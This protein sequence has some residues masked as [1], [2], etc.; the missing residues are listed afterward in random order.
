MKNKVLAVLAII[1]IIGMIVIAAIGF[2]VDR[3][4]KR[5]SLVEISIGKEFNINDIKTITDEVFQNS[6]VEIQKAGDFKDIVI[7]KTNEINDE[8]KETL[9]TKINEKYG[10]ENTIENVKVNE[11]SNFKLRDLVKPYIIPV[12]ISTILIL[13]YM[14]IRFKKLGIGKVI[15][16]DVLMIII[17]ELLYFAIIAI[18]RYPVNSLVMPVSLIIYVA[19]ITTLTGIFEKQKFNLDN[20]KENK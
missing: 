2:N 6:K 10:T 1:I 4:Y 19:I 5:Y 17:A 16:Q 9:N 20:V 13:V 18:T 12:I 3:N 15:L 14:A 7:I 8:Q 11:I